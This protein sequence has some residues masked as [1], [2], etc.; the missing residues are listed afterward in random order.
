MAHLTVTDSGDGIDA[1]I[2]EK[3][4][5]PFF[6]TKKDQKGTGIGLSLSRSIARRHGGDLVLDTESRNTTFRLELP[7]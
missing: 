2:A 1:K 6:T 3:V 5:T 4:M 7:L